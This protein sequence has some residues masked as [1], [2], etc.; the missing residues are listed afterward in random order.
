MHDDDVLA[1]SSSGRRHCRG[2]EVDSPDADGG[3]EMTFGRAQRLC[4][5]T[6]W[7]CDRAPR[8]HDIDSGLRVPHW[9]FYLHR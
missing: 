4:T 8:V 3:S 6:G 9:N 2:I 7:R 1:H 5:Q